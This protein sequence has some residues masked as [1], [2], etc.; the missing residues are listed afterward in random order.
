MERH[1]DNAERVVAAL[2][3]HPAVE[4]VLYPGL[5]S[6]PGHEVAAKQMR[7][8]GGMVSVLVR[9]GEDAA[10]ELCATDQAV[11]PGRVARRRGVADRAPGADDARVGG[12]VG[13]GGARRAGPVSVGIED[14]EDLV[15]DLLA[16]LDSLGS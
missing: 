2:V 9:G 4:R 7:R 10:L 3:G 8:F 1:C 12:R 6:H 16:A 5:A 13:A 14:A 11:H 15:D